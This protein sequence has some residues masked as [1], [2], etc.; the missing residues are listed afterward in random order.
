MDKE[1][2]KTQFESGYPVEDVE[3]VEK[4]LKDDGFTLVTSVNTFF[5]KYIYSETYEYIC[6]FYNATTNQFKAIS[7]LTHKGYVKHASLMQLDKVRTL[8]ENNPVRTALELIESQNGCNENFTDSKQ[9][10]W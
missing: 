6:L 1:A 9:S 5:P 4:I 8:C 2:I 10:E 3:T 7:K